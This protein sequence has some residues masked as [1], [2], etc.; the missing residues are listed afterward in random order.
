MEKFNTKCPCGK[1]AEVLRPTTDKG[2]S[3]LCRECF[4]K[5]VQEKSISNDCFDGM[6][7]KCICKECQCDCHK[8][9]TKD[10][11]HFEER[12]GKLEKISEKAKNLTPPVIQ[13]DK[14]LQLFIKYCEIYKNYFRQAEIEGMD[15]VIGHLAVI[16]RDAI[17]QEQELLRKELAEKI[18]NNF[19]SIYLESFDIKEV[20]EKILNIIKQGL[21]S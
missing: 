5:E 12:W 15:M 4:N 19:E 11:E 1:E 2:K 9:I 14:E 17:L 20:K 10:P 7:E 6:H 21:S 18:N 13:M 16:T 3:Q 8:S